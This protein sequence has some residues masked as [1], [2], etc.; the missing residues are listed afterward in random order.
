MYL[1]RV[2]QFYWT[3]SSFFR[4]VDYKY[5]NEY[6]TLEEVEFFNRLKKSEKLH[7]IRVSKDAA[8]YYESI[9]QKERL[10]DVSKD[11]VI[12][13]GLL[14]DIGKIKQPL[15]A[16]DKSIVVI[17]NKLTKGELKN[18]SKSKKVYIYYNHPEEGVKILKDIGYDEEF[19]YAVKNHHKKIQNP[20]MALKI[21]KYADNKN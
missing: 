16:I 19:L 18:K 20:S 6:L 3:I 4:K 11:M 1:Y 10:V 17:L 9:L 15:T 21:L 8:E 13:L 5:I 2:K 12:K 7:C 14:H